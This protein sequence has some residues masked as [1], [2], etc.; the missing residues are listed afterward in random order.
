MKKRDDKLAIV[1]GKFFELKDLCDSVAVKALSE[2]MVRTEGFVKGRLVAT[3]LEKLQALKLGMKE[4]GC[5]LSLGFLNLF[6]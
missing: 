6:F 2:E 4:F 3:S 1:K 5:Q